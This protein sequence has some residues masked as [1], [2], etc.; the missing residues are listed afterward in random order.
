M[1][2][3]RWTIILVDPSSPFLKDRT[4]KSTLACTDSSTKR[5]YM[6]NNLDKQLYLKVLLH[7]L[8]HCV[9]ISY[10][11]LDR[12]HKYTKPEHWI[13]MEELI[14]N[15]IAEYGVEIV[16][17]ANMVFINYKGSRII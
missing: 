6:S 2:G 9:T 4:G 5:I 3:I 8:S 10:H 1:N 7:E 11:L 16:T 13:D 15:I 14:C 17:I 12:I